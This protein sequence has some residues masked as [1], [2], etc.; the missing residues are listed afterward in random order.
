MK[1]L[2]VVAALIVAPITFAQ[3]AA[4]APAAPP[5]PVAVIAPSQPA[6]NIL[7]AG[8]KVALKMSEALTTKGKKL[9]VG[10][11]FQ[12]EVAEDVRLGD[13]T[14]IP[15]GTPA[16]GEV[17]DVRNKGMWGK[18]GRIGAQLLYMRVNG[19]QIRLSGQ[20][21]DKGVTGTAG[22]VGAVAFVP[23]AGFLMTGTS[24]TIPLGAPVSG[25]LDEDVPVV[26]NGAPPPPPLVVTQPK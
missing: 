21:D 24:A 15:A 1:S 6:D 5:A 18:S 26:F 22:V 14:V 10:Q 17:T 9:R 13:Q 20:L 4:P 8:T 25:F 19:R 16:T 3:T 12:L 11:R 7:R 23:I 2:A